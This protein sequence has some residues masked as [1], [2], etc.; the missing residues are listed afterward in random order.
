MKIIFLP[1]VLLAFFASMNESIAYDT[2]KPD[3]H[4]ESKKVTGRLITYEYG[5]YA[6]VSI[7]TKQGSEVSY[8]VYEEVCFLAA[9][10]EEEL[11]IKYDKIKRFFPEGNGYY[12][13][14]IIQSISTKTEERHWVRNQSVKQSTTKYQACHRNLRNL[15]GKGGTNETK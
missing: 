5:D 10:H 11:I 3:K 1:F 12:P 6:H 4:I 15:F 8:F 14:N 9:N 7:K 13:A 2:Q